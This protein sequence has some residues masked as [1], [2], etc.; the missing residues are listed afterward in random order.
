VENRNN[1]KGVIA[2]LIIIIAILSALCVLFATG[3]ISFN[4]NKE[5]DNKI[6]ENINM[7]DT[8]GEDN[9]NINEL[10]TNEVLSQL[11]GEWG[12]CNGEYDC[13]GIIISKNNDKYTY[14]PYI[15]WSEGGIGGEI[16][17]VNIISKNQY[18][19]IVYFAGYES[20]ESSA[21]EQT[22]K[23]NIDIKDLALETLYVNDN[24]YKKVTGDRETFFTKLMK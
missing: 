11:V 6:N 16:Q 8:D 19:L 20:V 10:T 23:Y 2:L 12:I 13:R 9:K 7:N 24:K 18:E 22:I 15:M 1:N 21:P 5:N 14:I 4:T 17:N 3:T